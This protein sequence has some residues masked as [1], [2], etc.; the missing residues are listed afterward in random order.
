MISR[1]KWSWEVIRSN[2]ANK[3][4][5][6]KKKTQATH[7]PKS[8]LSSW[9]HQDRRAWNKARSVLRASA[10]L[11]AAP[12]LLHGAARP[13][14]PLFSHGLTLPL[15]QK[16]PRRFQHFNNISECETICQKLIFIHY[17]PPFTVL[18]FLKPILFFSSKEWNWQFSFMS[19]LTKSDIKTQWSQECLHVNIPENKY[20]GK[21]YGSHN[22]AKLPE[23]SVYL[24]KPFSCI[25]HSE[26][27]RKW[28]K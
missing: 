17:I 19:L 8:P 27:W 12:H 18:C 22:M 2:I 16:F 6:R 13:V 15:V 26:I 3:K 7:F 9:L 24:K 21:W 25:L 1:T 5:R 23:W 28:Q 10:L 20:Q 4:N 11:C 14:T